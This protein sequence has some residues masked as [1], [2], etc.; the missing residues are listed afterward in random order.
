M[1]NIAVNTSDIPIPQ[2]TAALINFGLKVLDEIKKTNWE[3][4]VLLCGNQT[5]KQL[6]EQYRNKSEPSDVLSFELGANVPCNDGTSAFLAGDIVISVEML[7][8]NAA[9]FRVSE[10]EELRRLL[11]HGILHLDGMDHKTN[12]IQDPMILL[13]ET[14]LEKLKE[15]HILS[16]TDL[17]GKLFPDN[18]ES[19]G[20]SD[21]SSLSGKEL[22]IPYQIK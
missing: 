5:I 6:N 18:Y 7:R 19:S 3:L 1:N 17:S 8:E 15:E 11:I 20:N 13:Q 4:S 10:D 14:I 22:Q 12:E 2:W 21:C 9:Y 16:N